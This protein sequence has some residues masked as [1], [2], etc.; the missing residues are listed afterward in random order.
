MTLTGR[1]ALLALLGVVP[2]TLLPFGGSTVA[3]LLLLLLIAIAV[4]VA[5]AGP[6]SSLHVARDGATGCRLGESADVRL[7]LTNTGSR[8]VRGL[9][10]DAWVPSA[11]AGP[12]VQRLDVPAGERRVLTTTLLPTR[13][14][15]R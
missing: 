10:R 6:V 12:R 14:E 11:G 3:V 2:V 8:R 1:A 4:D 15:G 13:R 9:V 7:S 5:L